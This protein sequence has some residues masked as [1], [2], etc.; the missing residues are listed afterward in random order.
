M[1]ALESI[2]RQV[3]QKT[4]VISLLK[5]IP[6]GLGEIQDHWLNQGAGFALSRLRL[7]MGRQEQTHWEEL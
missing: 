1:G 3:Q 2:R 4:L 5:S 7:C 6:S